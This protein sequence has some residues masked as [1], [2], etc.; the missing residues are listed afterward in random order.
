M[1]HDQLRRA[2]QLKV[3]SQNHAGTSEWCAA[4]TDTAWWVDLSWCDIVTCQ[5]PSIFQAFPTSVRPPKVISNVTCTKKIF[6]V[7]S[8]QES[9]KK[10]DVLNTCSVDGEITYSFLPPKINL[11]C[12][13][14]RCKSVTQYRILVNTPCLLQFG[15]T[16]PDTRQHVV[17]RQP[18]TK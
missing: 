13:V 9:V 6:I 10:E 17:I 7:T 16:F 4:D 14:Y 8:H 12:H 1:R 18:P 2:G 5:C 11:Y 15:D 3:N